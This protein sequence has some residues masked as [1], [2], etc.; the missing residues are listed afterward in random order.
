MLFIDRVM[1]FLLDCM[2]RMVVGKRGKFL[3]DSSRRDVRC[4]VSSSIMFWVSF[5]QGV[6]SG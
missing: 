2:T 4:L 3:L 6:L 5:R 1:A